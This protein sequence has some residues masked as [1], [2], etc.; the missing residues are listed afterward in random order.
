[1]TKIWLKGKTAMEAEP[2]VKWLIYGRQFAGKKY[3][4]AQGHYHR[5]ILGA[6]VILG[7]TLR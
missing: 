3:K 1:M 2:S 6:A 4:F 5:S 7:K